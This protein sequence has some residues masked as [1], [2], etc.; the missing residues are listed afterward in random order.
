MSDALTIFDSLRNE[1]IRYY[2]TPFSVRDKGVMEER[3]AR[4]LED[5]VISREPWIEP[6]APYKN[7]PHDLQ[8]SCRIAGA[9][10]DLAEFA[11]LGLLDPRF[12]LRTHQEAALKAAC[13]DQKHVVIT[14]GTG[15]GKTEAFLLPLLSGLLE[16]SAG[17]AP[18][19]REPA[20]WWKD[21]GNAFVPQ[22]QGERGREAAVRAL[23]LY[24]MNALVEDQLQRLRH[25]LDSDASRAWLDAK[26]RGH[27]LYFGRYT[28]KTPVSGPQRAQ[29]VRTLK[30]QLSLL[31]ERADR[32]RDD[33]DRRYFLPQLDGAEM[34][35]RWDMQLFPPDI[36]ITN[37][38]MLDVMLMRRLEDGIFQKTAAWLA[39]SDANRFTVVVDELHMYRGTAGTEIAFLLRNLLLRL[40]I[41]DQPGKV[42]F[43]AASASAG[44]SSEEFLAFLEGFFAA[45]RASLSVLSG[46]LDLPPQPP[47]MA[48]VTAQRLAA[49]GGALR[50]ADFTGAQ[51]ALDAA[52]HAAG[53]ETPEGTSPSALLC[54]AVEADAALLHACLDGDGLRARAASD[55]AREL[56]GELSSPDADDA[57]RAL[58]YAMEQS[59]TERPEGSARTLRAHYFFRN[60]QGVWACC[61]PECPAVPGKFKSPGRRVGRIYVAPRLS[62]SCGARVLELLYCQ[63]C[64]ELYL[65]GWRSDDPDSKGTQWYLVGDVPDLERLPDSISGD[66]TADRYAVIWPDPDGTP[67]DLEYTKEG[68]LFKYRVEPCKLEPALGHLSGTL[69]ERTG[70]TI[71]VEHPHDR[72][73][74]ALPTKCPK[75]DDDWDA[76]WAGNP[77]D[78]GR[79]KSPIRF[80]RT[81]FEKVTQVLADALLREI[82][83]GGGQRK[84][85]AFTDSRQDAAKLSAGIE[86]RHYE[87]TVRQ[88]VARTALQGD[89]AARR[90][91]GA[92]A[93]LNAMRAG[94]EPAA[95]AADD[96]AWLSQNYAAE[97]GALSAQIMGYASEQQKDL[98][99]SFRSRIG[100]GQATVSQLS[101]RVETGLVNLGVNPG[102]PGIWKQTRKDPG[103]R[104]Y[105]PW[106]ELYD[107]K[108]EPVT[109]LPSGDLSEDDKAW[110]SDLRGVLRAECV[111]QV[112]APRRRDFESIG[113]GWVSIDPGYD[114]PQGLPQDLL[115]QAVASGIR[116]LGVERR[117][118]GRKDKGLDE[119]PASVRNYLSAVAARAQVDAFTLTEAVISAV[120]GS[121]AADQFVLEPRYLFVNVPA[122][123][124]RWVCEFCRQSHLHPS[125][126]VCVNCL[127]ALPATAA[128]LDLTADYY[129]YLAR[130]AGEPFRLHAEEL[131]GQTDWD[132]AQARQALFQGVFL[133]SDEIPVVDEIDLL[134]V[135]TTMEVGVDIGAL[136]AVLMGN[137]P[138][139]RFNYQQRVGRAGRRND[140]LAAA[141]TVCRGRSHDEYYFNNP[142]RIT[143]D[144]PPVP[145]LDM[146]RMEILRRSSLAEVMRRALASVSNGE[147]TS[148]DSVHGEFG[149]VED[150]SVTR[151][152]LED[153]LSSHG[154]DILNVARALM[155]GADHS[156]RA[157]DGEL[158]AFLS[159]GFLELVDK[160]V[161]E[162][163]AE[164]GEPGVALSE[165]L[166]EAGLL[167]MFGFPTRMRTLYTNSP[168]RGYPWPPPQT[169]QRDASVALSTWAP[170]SEVVKDRARHRVVGVAEYRPMGNQAG[171][172]ENA[173]GPQR[174][175]GQCAI[176]AT[177][178]TTPGHKSE[179][180]VCGA[181]EASDGNPGYRRFTIVQPLGYRTDYKK[182]EYTGWLEWSAASGSRPRMSAAGI[183]E[184]VIERARVG[185]GT[186]LIFEINDNRSR[187]W[188][189]AR[190]SDGHG[191]IAV[192]QLDPGWGFDIGYDEQHVLTVA[193]A[194]VK[195]TDVLVVGVDAEQIPPGFD[196]RPGDPKTR[197]A[198]YS[199]GFLLRGAAARYLDVQVGELDV[200]L[201]AVSVGG[202]YTAQIFMSDALANGAGY[203]SHLG[204]PE[205]FRNLL[206]HADAWAAELDTH[207]GGGQICD[208]ACYDC[209]L[210]YRNM[211]YHGLLDWRLALDMIDVLRGR[212]LTESRWTPVRDSG[213]QRFCAGNLGFSPEI[214]PGGLPCAA[215]SQLVVIPIHPLT[216]TDDNYMPEPVAEA[217]DALEAEGRGVVLTDYFNMLRRPAWVYQQALENS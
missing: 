147:A 134:S 104:N 102:G 162:L 71:N 211:A 163:L 217:V 18:N 27:R 31:G 11:Q 146:G 180:P 10:A 149:R 42:R 184:T 73:P 54:S 109:P 203:S 57:L 56:F 117:V 85:V 51:S 75:C 103:T 121:K 67:A 185:A 84:L 65:G 199:L 139:M 1:Y 35:S 154:G 160:R 39:A 13:S 201:R 2:E 21:A 48:A 60:V 63:T 213:L 215:D 194:A 50:A 29:S 113:L 36:L 7:V 130:E 119:P 164:H 3:H 123:A 205:I 133:G 44:A 58:L 94:D 116:I 83:R 140:P 189:L 196:L 155:A 141:L 110:L 14:A 82:A 4:L 16:E 112:F 120:K 177:V 17:W 128:E 208:S 152:R 89:P 80:M 64:G 127:S 105:R 188:R 62:C 167:P 99:S 114:L 38:S 178:D 151:G 143:G 46:D 156:L 197:A 214:A 26:R 5:G 204:Q 174:E 15:S 206:D 6:I 88:L 136:R 142:A 25:A 137:M 98:V 24:P 45:P 92:E 30:R 37:Y 69:G 12:S 200:G 150:W 169:I 28:G 153:W 20:A 23:V 93:Y 191:W 138:P 97:S 161:D 68:G 43:F 59:H 168:L 9:H 179:C 106:T 132:D 111:A 122:D 86:Q 131:T 52:A 79:A 172:V 210:D 159:G 216:S 74:P 145:Y 192:D 207:G 95:D 41:S 91:G 8:E 96:Y 209:L 181:P 100:H 129:A 19:T 78:P 107:W 22:R 77:E 49:A 124:Q 187:D 165:A 108:K 33:E 212:A 90:F 183:P 118:P 34:R 61:D 72:S 148:G 47:G 66:R 170:G 166:A 193:L 53:A 144:P 175:V 125:G 202:S 182:R 81:G 76:S 126:G 176:C 32:V 40:G 157:R 55:L 195:R 171:S 115:A 101:D 135:T 87:D 198:W 186:S 158:A 173:I 190:Q 70:W